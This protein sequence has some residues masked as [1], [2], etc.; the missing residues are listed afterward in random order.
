MIPSS[1]FTKENKWYRLKG[2]CFACNRGNV[3]DEWNHRKSD[4]ICDYGYLY[5][6][7]ECN[8]SCD[9]CDSPSFIL[10]WK[11]NC[12]FHASKKNNGFWEPRQSYLIAAIST[13]AKMEDIPENIF[14]EMNRILLNN[15]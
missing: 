11:F 3:N 2:K 12:G 8:I 14:R 5:I 1:K 4:C 9:E 10:H 15:K 13:L 7:P 6:N